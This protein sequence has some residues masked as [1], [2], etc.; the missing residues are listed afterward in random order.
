MWGSNLELQGI[1][2]DLGQNC[3]G[4]ACVFPASTL[5]I[6]GASTLTGSPKTIEREN[7]MTVDFVNSANADVSITSGRYMLVGLLSDV[8]YVG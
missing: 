8:F 3:A 1:F 4:E 6:L 5:A 2:K 7:K